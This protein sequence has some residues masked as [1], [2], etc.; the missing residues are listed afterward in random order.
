M[1]GLRPT[2]QDSFLTAFKDDPHLVGK[3]YTV[4]IEGNNCRLR[5]ESGGHL[6]KLVVFPKNY[7]TTGRRSIWPFS[8][9]ITASFDSSY[10][11]DH[12]QCF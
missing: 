8:T 5:L 11:V 10:F 7:L 9:S 3:K 6:E 12:H 1:T 4:G 2:T